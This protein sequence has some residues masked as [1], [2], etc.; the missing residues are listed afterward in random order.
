MQISKAP[1][2]NFSANEH[3]ESKRQDYKENHTREV[4]I[5]PYIEYS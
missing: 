2:F 5:S 4:F 3:Y 1:P